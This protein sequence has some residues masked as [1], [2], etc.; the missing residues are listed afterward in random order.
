MVA[1]QPTPAPT[2]RTAHPQTPP[3]VSSPWQ[4]LTQLSLLDWRPP[5][6]PPS[7][8][9]QPAC[10][11]QQKSSSSHTEVEICLERDKLAAQL[12]DETTPAAWRPRIQSLHDAACWRLVVRSEGKLRGMAYRFARSTRGALD[13]EDVFQEARLKALYWAARYDP[14]RIGEDGRPMSLTAYIILPVRSHLRDLCQRA[15]RDRIAHKSLDAPVHISELG[16]PG[17]VRGHDIRPD[18]AAHAAVEGHSTASM[19]ARA[20]ADLLEEAQISPR[21]RLVLTLL[22]GLKDSPTPGERM[23]LE[24][25]GPHLGIRKSRVHQ[26]HKAAL[27]QLREVAGD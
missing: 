8:L 16:C 19:A 6:P 24:E 25:A 18:P 7:A 17:A 14:C 1:H 20:I 13:P 22:Y 15:R 12:A 4:P 26:L 5:E 3:L 9:V 11:G 10:P 27:R 2:T 23:S 21:L